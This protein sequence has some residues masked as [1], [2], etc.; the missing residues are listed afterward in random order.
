MSQFGIQM[1]EQASSWVK[2]LERWADLKSAETK[3]ELSNHVTSDWFQATVY[4]S[5]WLH[6]VT[7]VTAFYYKALLYLTRAYSFFL[8]CHLLLSNFKL[9]RCMVTTR[10]QNFTQS[11]PR[12]SDVFFITGITMPTVSL[13]S[14]PHCA[15]CSQAW[16]HMWGKA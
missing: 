1:E 12:H 4:V 7:F 5:V 14:A 8:T 9:F 13:K 11:H 10:S 6:K 15:R 16:L 3:T 2:T